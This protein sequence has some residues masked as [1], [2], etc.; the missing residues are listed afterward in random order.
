[1][2]DFPLI[3]GNGAKVSLLIHKIVGVA[4]LSPTNTVVYVEGGFKFEVDEPFD[5]A[6]A[7]IRNATAPGPPR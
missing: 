6:R 3:G 1:M 2:L 5:A 4:A 7:K